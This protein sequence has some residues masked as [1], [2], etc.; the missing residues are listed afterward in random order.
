[1]NSSNWS[2]NLECNRLWQSSRNYRKYLNIKV[3]MMKEIKG[4]NLNWLRRK[5]KKKQYTKEWRQLSNR[6][7]NNYKN[8]NKWEWIIISS[9]KSKSCKKEMKKNRWKD[10]NS[11]SYF[12]K[13]LYN[14]N[15]WK[16]GKSKKKNILN[17]NSESKC[18][19]GWLNKKS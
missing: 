5:R 15:K 19:K 3:D 10:K 11:S 8:S 14:R 2:R 6:E 9:K 4:I 17:N 16:K 18:F 7:R 13:Q 12:K 1:M